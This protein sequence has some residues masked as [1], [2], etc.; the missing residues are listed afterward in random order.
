MRFWLKNEQIALAR[1]K[2]ECTWARR[3]YEWCYHQAR[4][5]FA[6]HHSFIMCT[7]IGGL[8]KAE[9]TGDL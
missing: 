2:S 8:A 4:N 7:M 9:Q 1:N 5:A 6:T 3:E